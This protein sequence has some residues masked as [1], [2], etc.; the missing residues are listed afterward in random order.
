MR[1]LYHKVGMFGLSAGG[2]HTGDQIRGFGFLHDGSVDTV[3][4]FVSAAAVRPD[5]CPGTRG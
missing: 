3:E 1:N 4:S 2:P 5:R